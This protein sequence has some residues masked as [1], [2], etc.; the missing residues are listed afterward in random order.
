MQT[1]A[2]PYAEMAR[3]IPLYAAR[4]AQREL[5][6]LVQLARHPWHKADV[7]RELGVSIRT[8]SRYMQQGL[9]YVK[10]WPE[11]PPGF[12][13][14]KVQAWRAAR[15]RW[16]TDVAGSVPASPETQ[17]GLRLVR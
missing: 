11:C 3:V 5:P 17:L 10:P 16:S 9:P 4:S 13:P 6:A 2:Q 7:A 8:V 12:A 14:L 15:G 1:L